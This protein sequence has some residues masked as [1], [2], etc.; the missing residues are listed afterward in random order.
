MARHTITTPGGTLTYA[1]RGQPDDDLDLRVPHQARRRHPAHRE[2][3]A[4]AAAR[5]GADRRRL[6]RGRRRRHP[7]RLRLGRPGRLLAARRLPHR[8][9]GA[10][11]AHASTS[12]AGSTRCCAS[13]SRRSCASSS[14]MKR[15][16]NSTSSKPAAGPPRRPLISPDLARG[17]LPAL[18]PE[19][20][21][22]PPRARLQ[23]RLPHLRRDDGHRG[24]SSS[25]TAAT[26]RKRWPRLSIG[27]NQEPWE[28]KAQDRRAAGP[29]RRAR[30][31]QRR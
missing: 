19:D 10:H 12:P 7:A 9:P 27:G 4:R 22:R 11:P 21:R 13:S 15:A 6:R 28:F 31:V 24:A 16:R 23:G 26:P 14:R 2:V 1:D 5:P 25:R 20:A 18:R 3:H 17:I 8:R 30:P 29:D